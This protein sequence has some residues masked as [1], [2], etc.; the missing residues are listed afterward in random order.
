MTRITGIETIRTR[1]DGTWLFVK[2]LTDQPGLYGIGSASDHY[3]AK[4]VEA[5]IENVTPLLIGRDASRIEDIW[6]SV[7]TQSYWRNEA[8]GNTVQAGIDMA[9]WDIKGKEAGMPVYQLLGGATR[10]AVAAYAHAQ[11]NSL[12]ELEDDVRRYRGDEDDDDAP[13]RKRRRDE[14]DDGA[15]DEGDEPQMPRRKRKSQVGTAK[16]VLRICAAVVGGEGDSLLTVKDNQPTLHCD[17]AGMFAEAG[18]RPQRPDPPARRRGCE[19]RRRAAAIR[20][21]TARSPPTPQRKTTA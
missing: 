8:I 18:G 7:H 15:E 1:A 21:P 16:L 12:A 10:S 14:D 4:V 3:R 17:L 9:L 20:H 19:L 6:Q 11:G 2:V 13:R 5:A